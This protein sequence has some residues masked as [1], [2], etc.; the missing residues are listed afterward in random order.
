VTFTWDDTATGTDLARIR[1][2]LG[3]TIVNDP[4]LTDEQINQYITDASGSVPRATISGANAIIAIFARKP[5]KT[6]A[7]FSC[8]RSQVFQHYKDLIAT[9][10]IEAGT[11]TEAAGPSW[12]ELSQSATDTINDDSDFMQPSFSIGR[13]DNE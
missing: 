1:A 10:Q 2:R 3:D 9:L 11:V 8:S 6:G 7:R 13:D 5:D 4:L 12:N